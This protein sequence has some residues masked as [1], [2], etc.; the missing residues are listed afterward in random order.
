MLLV[1]APKLEVAITLV[2]VVELVGIGDFGK[3]GTGI[4]CQRVEEDSVDD[5]A[6]CLKE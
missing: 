6:N 5:E 1:Q 4:L 3:N 2:G